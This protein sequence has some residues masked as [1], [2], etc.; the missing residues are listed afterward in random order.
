MSSFFPRSRVGWLRPN[1]NIYRSFFFL[2][3]DISSSFI[4]FW[5]SIDQLNSGSVWCHI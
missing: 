5:C 4:W 2:L 3:M 1:K